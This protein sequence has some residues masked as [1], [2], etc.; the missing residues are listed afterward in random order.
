MQAAIT[1]AASTSEQLQREAASREKLQTIVRELEA[2]LFGGKGHLQTESL[3]VETTE[4]LE[5]LQKECNSIFDR[6]K[7][8]SSRETSPSS[9]S[10][11][12]SLPRLVPSLDS[13]GGSSP[14][15]FAPMKR[16]SVSEI[17]RALEETEALVRTL[18]GDA[19][20]TA[21]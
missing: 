11:L 6:N 3:R 20:Q 17:H 4:L 16:S 18:V 5:S 2:Q 14:P 8:S 21:E 9:A 19:S 12:S 10:D 7:Q 13:E 15:F 1:E